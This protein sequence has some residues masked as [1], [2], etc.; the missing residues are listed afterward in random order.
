MNWYS[1][2]VPPKIKAILKREAPEN[3]WVK[4]PESGQLVFHKAIAA[5]LYVVPGSGYHMRCPAATRL[6]SLF[7]IAK[8]DAPTR[9]WFRLG[10][11]ATPLGNAS[12]LIAWSGSMFEYLMPSLVM[13]KLAKFAT[14]N[15]PSISN[16]LKPLPAGKLNG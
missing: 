15:A 11:L 3:L 7:A 5:N 1:N 13:P 9:H 8:G 6:A 10:R 2:V 16:S 4:C 14:S 12:A